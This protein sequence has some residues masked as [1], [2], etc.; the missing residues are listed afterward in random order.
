MDRDE[1]VFRKSIPLTLRLRPSI[2]LLCGEHYPA[3]PAPAE[4]MRM[5]PR[6]FWR[7]TTIASRRPHRQFSGGGCAAA[8]R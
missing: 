5:T 7:P 6:S 3:R 1:L 4:S 2:G 8:N